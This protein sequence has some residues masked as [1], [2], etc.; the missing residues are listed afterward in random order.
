MARAAKNDAGSI[1]TLGN[2]CQ[3]GGLGVPVDESKGLA[4]L[5]RA[6]DL[7]DDDSCFTIGFSYYTGSGVAQ[8]KA[9]GR[10][11]L[12]KAAAN[13]HVFAGLVLGCTEMENGNRQAAMRYW[14]IA[15]ACGGKVAAEELVTCYELDCIRHHD[16][17]ES[18]QARD[19]ACNEL[20]SEARDAYMKFL[21]ETGQLKADDETNVQRMFARKY[22][23]GLKYSAKEVI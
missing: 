17:A 14:R 1:E 10:K 2:I 11:Y 3:S 12:E 9:K 7:G 15:A 20:K 8:D 4:C 16:L 6:A 19:N 21:E 22:G 13:G 23:E 5:R 18:L